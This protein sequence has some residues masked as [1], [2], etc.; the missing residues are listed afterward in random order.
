MTPRR[1]ARG[2]SPRSKDPERRLKHC[3]AFV[4]RFAHLGT[5]LSL[6]PFVALLALAVLS[7]PAN[8]A[9]QESWVTVA[10]APGSFE[11]VADGRAATLV[12]SPADGKVVS[13]AADHL[14]TD[15]ECVTGVRPETTATP[16]RES[17][18]LV[19]IGTLGRAPLIDRLVT[20]GQLDVHELEGA[21]ESFVITTL[22]EPFPGVPQALVIVGSDRRG[23]AFG[24]FELSQAIGVSPWHWW[25]DVAPEKRPALFVS[26][27]TRRFGPPSVKFR[28]TFS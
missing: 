11:L 25:A 21:W 8:A 7:V 23:T 2:F 20:S 17:G 5:G 15:I 3:A 28:G 26:A 22:S 13:V 24:V 6:F 9:A 12:V 16:F 1:A 27:G 4:C 10:S 14:A 18:S 19:L